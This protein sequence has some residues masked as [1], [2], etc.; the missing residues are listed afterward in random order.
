MVTRQESICDVCGK[1]V[2]SKKCILCKKDLCS[3]CIRHSFEAT[4]RSKD[5]TAIIG[6]VVFCKDCK[7]KTVSQLGDNLFDEDFNNEICEKIGNYLIK[8]MMLENM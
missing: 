4:I 7:K 1:R 8:K 3:S 5:T 2:A 6:T